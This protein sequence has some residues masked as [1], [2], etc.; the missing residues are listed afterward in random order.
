M[1]F[2]SSVR[3]SIIE[4]FVFVYMMTFISN[5]RYSN[6]GAFLWGLFYDILID[7]LIDTCKMK[8]SF[9]LSPSVY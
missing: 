7:I 6:I 3:Y 1:T 9:L 8:N 5:V 2:I 4:A